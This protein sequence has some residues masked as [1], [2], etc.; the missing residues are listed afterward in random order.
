MNVVSQIAADTVPQVFGVRVDVLTALGTVG[1]VVVA[2]GLGLWVSGISTWIFRP[3]LKASIEPTLPDCHVVDLNSVYTDTTGQAHVTKISNQ[4]YCRL[5]IT[6]GGWFCTSATDVEL[7]LY[8]LWDVAKTPASEVTFL[9]LNLNWSH[10]PPAPL[11]PERSVITPLIQPKVF[12]HCDF[13]YVDD[14][15]P[16]VLVFSTEVEPNPINGQLA[17]RK[18]PGKYEVDLI[19]AGANYSPTFVT[20]SIEFSGKWPTNNDFTTLVA[21][22]V[23]RQKSGPPDKHPVA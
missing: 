12:R 20:V 18:P 21:V 2:L 9:P 8:Q 11:R 3:R 1:A 4:Y 19:L 17:T 16:D 5:R 6:N 23:V 10:V 13:C 7:R 14:R 15:Q 22:K